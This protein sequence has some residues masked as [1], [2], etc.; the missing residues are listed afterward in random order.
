VSVAIE[1]RL[2]SDSVFERLLGDV[3]AGRLA[4]AAPLPSE[5]VLSES[6]GVNR[7]AVR[8]AI[9]RLQQAGL[10]RVSQ[11]GATR[12]LDWRRNAGLDLIAD[13]T[14]AAR[15]AERREL[16]L[17]IAEMRA[18]I[19]A[20]VARLAAAARPGDLESLVV[21]PGEPYAHR[22]ERYADLWERIVE[23]AGNLAYRLS[24]NTLVAAQRRGRLDARIYAPEVDDPAA[25]RQ[26]VAALAAGD[27]DAAAA[28]A[29]AL[30]ARTVEGLR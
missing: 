26:L 13:L 12:V 29:G 19:G 15:G 23:H 7:H 21:D 28:L 8:E 14:A 11:G 9:K 24:F 30:L 27:A 1:R 2:L 25:Q 22:A 20:D 5:R 10:L 6:F 18:S 3:L 4:P 16:L 17:A